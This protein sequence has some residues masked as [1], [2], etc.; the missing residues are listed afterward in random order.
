MWI[1]TSVDIQRPFACLGIP[2]HAAWLLPEGCIVQRTPVYNA[3]V[4]DKAG[5]N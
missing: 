3:P 5:A 2:D 1:G 4:D